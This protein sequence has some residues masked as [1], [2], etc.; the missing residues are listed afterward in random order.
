M[1][2]VAGFEPTTFRPPDGRAA[3]LRHT[4][5]DVATSVMDGRL[6]SLPAREWVAA[7]DLDELVP[8]VAAA[9]SWRGVLRNLGLGE[10][11]GRV[12]RILR[13]R[14]DA[15]GLDHSHFGQ[16]RWRDS[17]LSLAVKSSRSWH[18][19]MAALG[20]AKDSG[21]ARR[22]VRAHCLRLKVDLSAIERTPPPDTQSDRSEVSI[23]HLRSAGPMLV[24]AALTLRGEWPGPWSPRPTISWLTTVARDYSACR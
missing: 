19:L 15:L 1:V 18:D 21:S 6:T 3:K 23:R 9:T 4:P 5:Q 8:A 10:S 13:E 24:A 11:N 14:C 20:Y 16:R 2:G 12:G 17:E 22:T 7:L